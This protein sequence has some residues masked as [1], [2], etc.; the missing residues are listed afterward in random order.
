MKYDIFKVPPSR[1]QIADQK[2]KAAEKAQKLPLFTVLYWSLLL[3]II[4][5]NF[6]LGLYIQN[7]MWKFVAVGSTSCLWMIG[8]VFSGSFLEDRKFRCTYEL[9]MHEYIG[10]KAPLTAVFEGW[11]ERSSQVARYVAA[12]SDQGRSLT[13]G[14]YLAVKQHIASLRP[15]PVARMQPAA[16]L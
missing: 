14:E 7:T 13:F 9:Q 11:C 6:C 12:V 5:V 1:H 10:S 4:I 3:L 2:R 8:L 15:E 16:E